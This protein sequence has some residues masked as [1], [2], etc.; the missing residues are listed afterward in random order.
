MS[1]EFREFTITKFS[2]CFNY[3]DC[4]ADHTFDIIHDI[5]RIY[6]YDRIL[7]C[8]NRY[9]MLNVYKR[10]CG[11]CDMIANIVLRVIYDFITPYIGLYV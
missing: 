5:I 3:L 2:E 8:I 11:Y 1:N 6:V 10:N 9:Q 4:G 7:K